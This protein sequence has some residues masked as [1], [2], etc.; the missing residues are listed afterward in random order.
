MVNALSTEGVDSPVKRI[1]VDETQL[2]SKSLEDFVSNNTLRFFSI[3]GINAG[4]LK[5][6][7]KIGKTM[8]ILNQAE[9]WFDL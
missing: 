3:T 7:L 6:K 8:Q 5:K 2:H 4:F 9:N 1:T